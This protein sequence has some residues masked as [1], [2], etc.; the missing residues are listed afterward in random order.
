MTLQAAVDQMSPAKLIAWLEGRDKKEEFWCGNQYRC[1]I[2][3]YL[4]EIVG[5][6]IGVGYWDACDDIAAPRSFARLPF[7]AAN[8][9]ESFDAGRLDH[10]KT[11]ASLRIVRRVC[12]VTA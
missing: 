4:A 12:G 10:R 8:V 6:E 1:L 9:I 3:I 2:A 7:W 11:A 5:H